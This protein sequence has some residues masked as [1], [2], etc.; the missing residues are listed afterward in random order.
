MNNVI[1]SMG[2]GFEQRVNKNISFSAY[3]SGAG[4]ADGRGQINQSYKGINR[5]SITARNLQHANED[6]IAAQKDANKF[7]QFYVA[8]TGSL[9][10]FYFYSPNEATT[11][12]LTGLSVT[13]RYLVRFEQDMLSREMF[14]FHLFNYSI[15]LIEVRE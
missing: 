7:W 10:P 12:D 3:V 11:I 4:R 15:S 6:G 2:D 14:R 13:G 9:D 8:R 1:M 5:F